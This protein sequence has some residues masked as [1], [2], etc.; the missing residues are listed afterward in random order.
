[1]VLKIFE[2]GESHYFVVMAWKTN[3]KKNAPDFNERYYD[4]ER[5]MNVFRKLR[6]DYEFVE[7]YE[8]IGGKRK[9]INDSENAA[10]EE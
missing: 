6:K 4:Y 2:A 1:M 3:R 5:A 7:I 8:S 9:W 10:Q